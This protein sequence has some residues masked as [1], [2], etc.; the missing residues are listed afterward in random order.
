MLSSFWVV[1]PITM[2]AM[3]IFTLVTGM[4]LYVVLLPFKVSLSQESEKAIATLSLLA[5]VIL[6]LS[7]GA[8]LIG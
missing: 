3:G 8:Y 6:A 2:V 7:L 1:F 4:I 5:G